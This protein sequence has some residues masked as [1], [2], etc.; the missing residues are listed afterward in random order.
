MA[1]LGTARLYHSL[2]L[3]LPDG[4]VLVAGGGRFSDGTAPTDKFSGELYSP[5]Y[6]FKGARPVITSAPATA[7]YG[8]TFPFRP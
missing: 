2:A 3:L 6:I 1:S 7:T 4:R 8:G 5:P